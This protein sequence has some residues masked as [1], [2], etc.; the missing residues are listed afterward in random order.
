MRKLSMEEISEV[1]GG[2]MTKGAASIGLA[3]GIGAA[4]FG[5]SWGSLGVGVA[6]AASPV[7]VLAVVALTFY[8]GYSMAEDEDSS[9][10]KSQCLFKDTISPI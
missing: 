4:A 8:G 9:D 1:S 6:A 3:G 10:S 7:A 2:D 5:A